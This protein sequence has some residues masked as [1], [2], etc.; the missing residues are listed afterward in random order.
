MVRKIKNTTLV[1]S[2]ATI[3]PILN[4]CVPNIGGMN[5][6]IDALDKL[7]SVLIERGTPATH[8]R[9][10]KVIV[11][12]LLFDHIADPYNTPSHPANQYGKKGE[13]EENMQ[14]LFIS[15]SAYLD[16][17][18]PDYIVILNAMF[19]IDSD[20]DSD[21]DSDDVLIP[22]C[23]YMGCVI[24]AFMAYVETLHASGAITE[25]PVQQEPVEQPEQQEPVEQPE[26]QEPPEQV[27]QSAGQLEFIG[28]WA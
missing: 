28:D 24:V 9:S 11:R 21:S 16:G 17:N 14:R 5:R 20:S 19:A 18:L 13:P 25:V 3:S 15:I 23:H 27:E 22:T 1:H 4:G 8:V 26:Q 6:I 12:E 7:W 10:L 2:F